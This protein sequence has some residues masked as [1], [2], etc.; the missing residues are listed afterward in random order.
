MMALTESLRASA[1]RIG[2]AV[3]PQ[4][5]G[6]A[7]FSLFCTPTALSNGPAE[8][9]LKVK[10]TPL[11]SL[12]EPQRVDTPAATVQ[13][14]LWRTSQRPSRG[15]VLPLVMLM[16][17]KTLLDAGF[18][19]VAIDLPMGAEAVL[20]VSDALGR[21]NR[22]ANS[23]SCRV[24]TELFLEKELQPQHSSLPNLEAMA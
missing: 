12:A 22:E 6:K 4:V 15:R 8:Q 17:V 11:L 14:Y 9:R 19:C 21:V 3:A 2:G 13:A 5:V 23:S 10:L 24:S 20:A 18:D 7:A 16:F 1:I